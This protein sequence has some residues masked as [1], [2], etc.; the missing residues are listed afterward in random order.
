VEGVNISVVSPEDLVLS[1]LDWGKA[2]LS[3]LQ[4]RD[5]RGIVASVSD[6]DWEY[7]REWAQQLA[8]TQLLDE[9]IGQ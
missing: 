7:L 5:V 6:L 1:K 3:E 8:L 4:M 2:S 9:A